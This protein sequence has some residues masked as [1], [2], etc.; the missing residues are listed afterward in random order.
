[1]P[2]KVQ[3]PLAPLGLR[4]LPRIAPPSLNHQVPDAN[5]AIFFEQGPARIA[6]FPLR[7]LCAYLGNRHSGK[8]GRGIPLAGTVHTGRRLIY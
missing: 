8:F 3:E 7:Y 1:M 4:L 5:A 6:A 2:F